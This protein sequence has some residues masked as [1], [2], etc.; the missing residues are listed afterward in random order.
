[1]IVSTRRTTITFN[2]EEK[3]VDDITG[4]FNVPSRAYTFVPDRASVAG[5]NMAVEALPEYLQ[6]AKDNEDT[7]WDLQ[8]LVFQD[9]ELGWC[10]I[11]DW[12]VDHGTNIVFY[13]PVGSLDPVASEEH[14]SLAEVL[15]WIQASPSH[16]RLSDYK[17]SR[18]VEYGWL[19]QQYDVPQAFLRSDA[20]CTIF[21]H[22]PK[23]QSDYPGQILKLSKSDALW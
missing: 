4:I 22:P 6:H 14:A 1:M 23:G 21:V 2:F 16:P 20:D 17:S 15:M 9:D 19:I 3:P 8:G 13:S 10:T 18:A 12:G 11:T 5:L 7:A